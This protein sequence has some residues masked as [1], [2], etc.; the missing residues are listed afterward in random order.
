MCHYLK[1]VP[2]SA[3]NYV[4]L[5]IHKNVT[6]AKQKDICI[7]AFQRKVMLNNKRI[8]KKTY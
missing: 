8:H 5:P 7:I 2:Q 1:L 3:C 6:K 4:N